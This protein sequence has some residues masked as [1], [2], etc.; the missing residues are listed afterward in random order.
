MSFMALVRNTLHTYVGMSVREMV[1]VESEMLG[2][3]GTIH[4]TTTVLR[5]VAHVV[6]VYKQTIHRSGG[7]LTEKLVCGEK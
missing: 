4:P 1:Y 3:A 7:A 6:G 5:S 2:G